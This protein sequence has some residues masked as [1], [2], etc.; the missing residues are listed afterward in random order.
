MLQ[1]FLT[2]LRRLSCGSMSTN[3]TQVRENISCAVN[4]W[5]LIP[6]WH[7][8]ELTWR[9]QWEK[10]S[11]LS[12]SFQ[13]GC[14]INFEPEPYEVLHSILLFIIFHK[15]QIFLPC[16]LH[17]WCLFFNIPTVSKFAYP[18]SFTTSYSW[19]SHSLNEQLLW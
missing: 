12:N 9:E 17:S 18:N 16:S 13:T 1:L 8:I 14:S 4:L 7:N 6:K 19:P 5:F 15:E 10:Q 11:A 2:K 3:I